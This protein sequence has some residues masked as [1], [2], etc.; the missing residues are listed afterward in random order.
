MLHAPAIVGH[1]VLDVQLAPEMLHLPGFGVQTGGAHVDTGVHTFSGSGGSFSQPG[2]GGEVVRPMPMV[3]RS[4]PFSRPPSEILVTL[5]A[6]AI[7]RKA[8]Q[9]CT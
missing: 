6:F 2:G 1:C 3:R 7:S 9:F 8:R 4:K 5:A